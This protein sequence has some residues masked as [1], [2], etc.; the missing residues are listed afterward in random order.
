MI[1]LTV[2]AGVLDDARRHELQQ[3]LAAGGAVVRFQELRAMA[4]SERA[5]TS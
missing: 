3:M 5:A 4:A 1:T 2:P